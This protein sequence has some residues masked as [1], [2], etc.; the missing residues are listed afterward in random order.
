MGA[1]GK[2]N[3]QCISEL[4]LKGL[5]EH[6]QLQSQKK[7]K[8]ITRGFG[9]PQRTRPLLST[10]SKTIMT[11]RLNRD[12]YHIRWKLDPS[13]RCSLL[14]SVAINLF[15][16]EQNQST[17]RQGDIAN[18]A[19]SLGTISVRVS[20]SRHDNTQAWAQICMYYLLDSGNP[21]PRN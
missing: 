2:N 12:L 7:K 6:G 9:Y 19:R 14:S 11:V 8:R 21:K 4:V 5:W 16:V 3:F 10:R 1:M 17:T 15:L 18:S 20:S 13:W